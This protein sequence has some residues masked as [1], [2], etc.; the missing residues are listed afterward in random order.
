MRSYEWQDSGVT[1]SKRSLVLGLLGMACLA[2]GSFAEVRQP[3]DA[4]VD[5]ESFPRID[6]CEAIEGSS[7][8]WRAGYANFDDSKEQAF[9]CGAD[10]VYVKVFQYVGRGT[11]EEAVG[12]VDRVMPVEWRP[13]T[14]RT[15]RDVSDALSVQEY[16]VSRPEGDMTIWAWYSVGTRHTPSVVAVKLFEALDLISRSNNPTTVFL[17]AVDDDAGASSLASVARALRSWRN[18]TEAVN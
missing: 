9:R 4:A 5:L 3:A 11:R 17:V 8:E 14:T 7:H 16:R 18:R 1:W 10:D 13:H 2:F 12:E 15:V 6:G